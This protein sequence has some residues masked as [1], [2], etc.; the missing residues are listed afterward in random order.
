MYKI[1]LRYIYTMTFSSL[2][3]KIRFELGN[4]SLSEWHTNI[5]I[6]RKRHYEERLAIY[7]AANHHVALNQNFELQCN[8]IFFVI[9]FKYSKTLKIKI[10]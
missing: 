9:L 6:D 3:N 7:S 4:L 1:T 10:R 8:T 5:E 2:K